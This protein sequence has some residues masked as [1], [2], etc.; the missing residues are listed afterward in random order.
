MS[1]KVSSVCNKL[2]IARK[3]IRIVSI[4]LMDFI[5]QKLEFHKIMSKKSEL[6]DVNSQLQ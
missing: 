6:Q 5:S 1:Y 3:N 2:A 4:N